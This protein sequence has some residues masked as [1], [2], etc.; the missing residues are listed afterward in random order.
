M[1]LTILRRTVGRLACLAAIVAAAP[2]AGAE[3]AKTPV[4]LDFGTSASPVKDVY[5]RLDVRSVYDGKVGWEDTGALEERDREGDDPLARDFVY[6]TRPATLTIAL[7][8]GTYHIEMLCGDRQY[9]HGRFAVKPSGMPAFQLP[10]LQ[11]DQ[12]AEVTFYAR[13]EKGRLGVSFFALEDIW[14]V[15]ALTVKAVGPAG[16][17]RSPRY[18]LS[19]GRKWFEAPLPETELTTPEVLR[20]RLIKKPRYD[21]RTYPAPP[22][23][24]RVLERFP[25]L[26][27]ANWTD[28]YQSLPNLGY[29]GGGDSGEFGMRSLGNFVFI[30][31]LLATDPAYDPRP[32]GV[33]RE[34]LLDLAKQSL[35]YM[36]RTHVTGDLKCTN[37]QAWGNHWQSAWWTGKMA[38]GVALLWDKLS[39]EERAAAERVIVFEADRHLTRRAPGGATGNTRSEENAWDTE[40]MAWAL[41]LFPDH[42]NA[43]KWWR[44]LQDFAM[45]TLSA[46][47]D[48]EDARLVD[49]RPVRNQVYTENIHA[50]FTIENHG[51]YHFCYMACPLHSLTWSWYGLDSLGHPVPQALSHHYTD[52]YDVIDKAFLF[53]GRFAYMSGK[54][55]PRYAY[56]LYFI[57]PALVYMQQAHGDRDARLFERL[58]FRTFEREQI[59]N[60]DGTFF[61]PRFTRAYTASRAFEFETD[62]YANLGLCYLMHKRAAEKGI[63]PLE[64]SNPDDYQRRAAG[65]FVSE[66]SG[67]ALSR[68]PKLF[69]SFSWRELL[70]GSPL[71]LFVPAGCDDMAEWGPY[72]LAGTFTIEGCDLRKRVIRHSESTFDG[73]FLTVGC[74]TYMRGEEAVLDHHLAF[75]SLPEEGIA[76]LFDRGVASAD[77]TVGAHEGLRLY[78]AN[79]IFNSGR[80]TIESP[81]GRFDLWGGPHTSKTPQADVVRTLSVPWL[82]V[83]GRL[84][85]IAVQADAPFVV[86]DVRGRRAAWSSIEYE[87]VSLPLVTEPRSFRAGEVVR[88]SAFVLLA[89]DLKAAARLSAGCRSIPTGSSSVKCMLVPGPRA[90]AVNFGVQPAS[91]RAEINGKSIQIDIGAESA[92]VKDTR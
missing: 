30:S 79:D 49:H 42:P 7:P 80:R 44:K 65:T 34:R 48:R 57:M 91:I 68:S 86:Q 59:M 22:D 56:G 13:S 76:L 63:H 3:F 84:S 19:G 54:D 15:N 58:R 29:A 12:Y 26:A 82:T 92:V 89:G 38:A 72:Q 24:M 66:D 83:D 71:G 62:A 45:N 33:S 64:P 4:N 36:T 85:V 55:W 11:I 51:A 50:D 8:D 27:E 14:L 18:R 28:S 52:V 70:G 46:P 69:T 77:V 9:R 16:S 23:Y 2:A 35:N 1:T 61:G 20:L 88:D 78:V 6:S 53:D 10:A 32:T 90:I 75:V 81:Q 67:F 43:P 41:G 73:G 47:Q 21:D 31:A 17:P 5:D 25:L 74:M 40:V 37:G 39:V 87:L 60:G